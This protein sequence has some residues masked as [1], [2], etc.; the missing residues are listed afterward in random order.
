[1]KSTKLLV[2]E[3]FDQRLGNYNGHCCYSVATI[4][5]GSSGCG[6]WVGG[7]VDWEQ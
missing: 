4:G 2:E 1:M 6:R 7:R 5:G 3:I